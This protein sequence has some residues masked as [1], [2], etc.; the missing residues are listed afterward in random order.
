MMISS[1]CLTTALAAFTVLCWEVG[2]EIGFFSALSLLHGF[3]PQR[4][5]WLLVAALSWLCSRLADSFAALPNAAPAAADK[6]AVEYVPHF[7]VA[8]K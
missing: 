3:M 2:A 7:A 5:W 4:E 1:L 6:L 8:P